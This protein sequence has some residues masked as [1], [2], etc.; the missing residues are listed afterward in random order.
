MAETAPAAW[1]Q[2]HPHF[3]QDLTLRGRLTWVDVS[4]G[5]KETPLYAPGTDPAIATLTA[6]NERLQ[7]ELDAMRAER[8]AAAEALSATRSA[9][10]KTIE[11]KRPF[12]SFNQE[13]NGAPTRCQGETEFMTVK[14]AKRLMQ[15][16]Y[17]ELNRALAALDATSALAKQEPTA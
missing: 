8:G 5:W 10:V 7:R 2:E 3:G 11:A 14:E 16:M 15:D 4:D 13:V 17:S 9:I 6:A 1:L 12:A